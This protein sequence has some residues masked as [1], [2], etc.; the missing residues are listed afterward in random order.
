MA[1][2]VSESIPARDLRSAFCE[3][4]KCPPSEFEERALRR[5][6]YL[7]AKLTAPLLRLY[8]QDWFK[9]D[10]LFLRDLGNAKSWEQIMAELDAYHFREH[11]HPGFARMKLR[12]RVSARK[13]NR[14]AFG[15]F[16]K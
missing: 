6:L 9:A 5:C 1:M 7:P 8:D 4:F 2:T 12:L 10:L 13:A 11:L 16:S 3:R 14:M 15:L